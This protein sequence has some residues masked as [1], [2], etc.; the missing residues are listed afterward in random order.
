VRTFAARCQ[1]DDSGQVAGVEALAFGFLILVA[2]SL[3]LANAWAV[4]DAK[5]AATAAAREATRIY[6]ESSSESEAERASLDAARTSIAS[7][8]RDPDDMSLSLAS[9][10]G[11][12]RCHSVVAEVVLEVPS[13]SLPFIGGF[14]RLFDVRATHS[15]IVDPYR[16]GLVGPAMCD[17]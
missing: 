8:G 9:D 14:G 3:L 5:F 7:H 17:G 6:V 13:V 1:L 2:G 4:V 12:G 11:F 16:S 15:E 10:G